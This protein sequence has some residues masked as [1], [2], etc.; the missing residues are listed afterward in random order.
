VLT[1]VDIIS[2]ELEIKQLLETFTDKVLTKGAIYDIIYENVTGS[3]L[4]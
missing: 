4:R 2:L 3:R 1:A